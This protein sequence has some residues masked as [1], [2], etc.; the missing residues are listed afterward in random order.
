MLTCFA[1]LIKHTHL[2]SFFLENNGGSFLLDCLRSP[3]N[4]IQEIYYSLLNLWLV[5]FSEEGIEKFIAVPGTK[6]IKSVCEIL[7]R[8]S[9]EKITRMAFLF[10]KN[11]E[12][13]SK[14][15]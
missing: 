2:A 14:C 3:G 6:V 1:H 4:D 9:R 10:F 5:S 11:I 13:S 7:Q 12:S 8:V 15:L